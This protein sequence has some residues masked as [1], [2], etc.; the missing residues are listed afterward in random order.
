M[1]YLPETRA[2]EVKFVA[3]VHDEVVFECTEEQAEYVQSV[4]KEEM[5]KAGSQF[6]TDLPCISEVFINDYWHKY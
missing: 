3:T 2:L 4:V 1:K 6:I 5:E